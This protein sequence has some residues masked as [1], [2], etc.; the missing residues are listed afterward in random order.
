MAD[1]SLRAQLSRVNQCL[2][3]FK[4]E[5][6]KSPSESSKGG[7]GKSPFTKEVQD[8]SVPLNFRLLTLETYDGGSDPTEHIFAFQAQLALFGTSDA[9]M[10]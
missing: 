2:D 5:F 10:C 1:D 6:Q 4:R 8:K 7:S 3:E 9:L